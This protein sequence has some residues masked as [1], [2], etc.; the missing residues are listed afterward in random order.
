[1]FMVNTYRWDYPLVAA[2]VAPRP[3]LICNSDKDTIFPLDGVLR[4]HE[5]VR[6]V[7]D[8][9]GASDKL[10]LLITEG[11]HKDTQ[12]LQVPVFRWFN[13]FLKND[14]SLVREAAEP[15]FT[16]QQL[17]VFDK[18]P[19]DEISSKCYEHFTQLASE[20]HPLPADEALASL[21]SKTF[22][23][24]PSLAASPSTR[25][26]SSAEKEGIRFSVHEF[27]SQPGMVL[28]YYM[29]QPAEARPEAIH[30]QI[31]DESAWHEQLKLGRIAFG[32]SLGEELAIA[33]GEGSSPTAEETGHLGKWFR[34]IK[35]NRAAYVTFT[36]RG[37]GLTALGGDEKYRVQVRRRF[38]LLGQTLAG[39]Q[40]WDFRR[41]AQSIKHLQGLENVPLHLHASPA[42]TEVGTF[43]TLFEPGIASLTL[44][45]PPRSDKQASDFLNW[46]RIVT[47]AQLLTL[48][49]GRTKV[50]IADPKAVGSPGL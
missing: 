45:E 44:P 30:L 7:Y 37:V 43:A 16:A 41:A 49:Q 14:T 25:E 12:E 40:T 9:Y 17:K 5:K 23:A 24:W 20:S 33:P 50:Q 39:M 35:E 8:L 27:E 31:V 2:L 26:L 10:G 4:L 18:L 42:M 11:P 32:K 3:L 48:A 36:P 28:R 47:P 19:T 6:R 15:R 1:M 22:G 13:R 46:S 21:G 38:M 29:A 34:Y